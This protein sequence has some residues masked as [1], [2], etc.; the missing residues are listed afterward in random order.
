MLANGSEPRFRLSS[1]YEANIMNLRI[2]RFVYV[3][4][5][6]TLF[7]LYKTRV[8]YVANG[9]MNA[10]ICHSFHLFYGSMF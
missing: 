9:E 1:G 4:V 10:T 7:F 5:F 8:L 2:A 6:S 3:S